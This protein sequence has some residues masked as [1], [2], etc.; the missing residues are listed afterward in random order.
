MIFFSA[1]FLF[2]NIDVRFIEYMP[3]DGNK[4]NTDKMVS[5]QVRKLSFFVSACLNVF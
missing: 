1:D 3:F 5:Y 4:W 2:S